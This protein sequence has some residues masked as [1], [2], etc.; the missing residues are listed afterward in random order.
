MRRIAQRAYGDER[1]WNEIWAVNTCKSGN[2]DLIY[3]GEIIIIPPDRLK[4]H[5]AQTARV[6]KYANAPANSYKF[7]LGGRE[8]PVSSLRIQR[9]IDTLFDSWIA[10]IAWKPGYDPEL[11]ALVSPYAYTPSSLYLGS[12]LVATGALYNVE[13]HMSDK[14][15]SKVLECYTRTCDLTDSK[16]IPNYS[17]Q[18]SGNTVQQIA[19]ELLS[20]LGYTMRFLIPSNLE[21]PFDFAILQKTEPYG[22]FL[23]RL[24]KSRALLVTNDETGAVVFMQPSSS[25]PSVGTLTD[26]DIMGSAAA[27]AAMGAASSPEWSAKFEG[28][29]RFHTYTV[30]CQGGDGH[31]IQSQATD[32]NVLPGRS[33]TYE[34]DLNDPSSV[35]LSASWERSKQLVK[36]LSFPVPV[37]SWYAPNGQ[38]WAPGQL[39]TI[40]SHVLS[41]PLGFKFLVRQTEHVLDEHGMVCTLQVCPP[42]C[43]TGEPLIEPWFPQPSDRFKKSRN[44][45]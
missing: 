30:I 23:I 43:Y 38:L 22:S 12:T 16:M 26:S 6:S 13:P 1:R 29:K 32:D 24:A 33:M 4:A 39:V 15:V 21:L 35:D 25:G 31:T 20:R 9:S 19:N 3:P 36:A 44:L 41:V 40:V 2:P 42:Q 7:L 17:Y 34:N 5:L 8:V 11:D 18:W 10:E 37:S 45:S 14:G 27:Q 28:R